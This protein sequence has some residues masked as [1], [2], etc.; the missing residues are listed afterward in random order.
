MLL[1][2]IYKIVT[3]IWAHNP[4]LHLRSTGL[5]ERSH[6][7][8]RRRNNNCIASIYLITIFNQR[9]IREPYSNLK[10][11]KNERD[12]RHKHKI[13]SP[14]RAAALYKRRAGV[15]EKFP[16]RLNVHV[17]ETVV[18]ARKST[19]RFASTSECSDHGIAAFSRDDLRALFGSWAANDALR[20]V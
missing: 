12:N 5:I 19:R 18:A 15:R 4:S 13:H 17:G 3:L 14:G 7:V 2:D 9:H 1:A 8:S 10:E 11:T 6:F 20:D 16:D